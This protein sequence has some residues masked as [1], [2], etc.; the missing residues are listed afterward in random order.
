M[1]AWFSSQNNGLKA[2]KTEKHEGSLQKIR[3]FEYNYSLN[4][5]RKMCTYFRVKVGKS[6]ICLGRNLLGDALDF[7]RYIMLHTNNTAQ[8]YLLIT[9]VNIIYKNAICFQPHFIKILSEL[10]RWGNARLKQQTIVVKY[11]PIKATT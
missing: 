8:T 6:S 4:R 3:K 1:P 2:Q 11:I 9:K 10:H 5:L 7:K